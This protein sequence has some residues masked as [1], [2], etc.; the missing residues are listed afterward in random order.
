MQMLGG[1]KENGNTKRRRGCRCGCACAHVQ[2]GG[3]TRQSFKQPRCTY[4]VLGTGVVCTGT[5][6]MDHM[7][8]RVHGVNRYKC[9]CSSAG[10]EYLGYLSY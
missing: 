4:W 3:E 2:C 5:E 10:T 1:G 7:D 6:Y 9:F 8:M